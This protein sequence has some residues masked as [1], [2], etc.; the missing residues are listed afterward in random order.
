MKQ[1]ILVIDDERDVRE[2]VASLLALLDEVHVES[3]ATFAAGRSRVAE[4]WA[5]VISDYA[6]PDGNGVDLLAACAEHQP[7]VPRVLMTAYEGDARVHEALQERRLDAFITKPFDP[8]QVLE[9]VQR[10]LQRGP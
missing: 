3:E 6:L 8:D 4:D 10:L 9:R 2:C 5:M 1:R 7:G